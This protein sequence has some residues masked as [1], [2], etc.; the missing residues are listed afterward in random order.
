MQVKGL[1]LYALQITVYFDTGARVVI[2]GHR[3]EFRRPV[4]AAA[5]R[6]ARAAFESA[7]TRVFRFPIAARLLRRGVIVRVRVS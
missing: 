1:K 3:H 2:K 5:G 6:A 4:L 7:L